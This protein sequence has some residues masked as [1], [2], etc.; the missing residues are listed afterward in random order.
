MANNITKKYY[1]KLLFSSLCLFILSISS[2]SAYAQL[3]NAD[4]APPSVKWM[5]I[6]EEAFTLIYPIEMHTIAQDAANI[7]KNKLQN[8]GS[9][10]G[11]KPRK[12]SIILQNGNVEGNGYVQLAPRK[13]ELYT[14]PPQKSNPSDW[15]QNL[16]I[17]EY[18]H[19]IQI[20]KLTGKIQFPLEELG[21]AFFGIALPTWF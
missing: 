20:D 13:S 10:L 4:Q 11:I 16:I 2:Y 15:V 6:N 9:E 3:I 21:F 19:V 18:R 7:L 14:T 12:I 1:Y 8:M 5:Q 17:H